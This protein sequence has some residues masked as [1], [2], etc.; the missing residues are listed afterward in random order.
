MCAFQQHCT[1]IILGRMFK[2]LL[3]KHSMAD[4]GRV[5]I[6]S[7]LR[8]PPR[9]KLPPSTFNR[10]FKKAHYPARSTFLFLGIFG[11]FG[12]LEK[13]GHDKRRMHEKRS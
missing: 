8:S 12:D 11:I 13:T 10:D 1:R 4:L 3:S 7:I 2:S 6:G 9:R 5:Y